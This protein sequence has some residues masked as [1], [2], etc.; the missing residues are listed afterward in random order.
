MAD[1]SPREILERALHLWWAIA[2]CMLL[3]G[4]AA[5]VFS[6]SHSPIYEATALYQVTLDQQQLATRLGLDPSQLP[7]DFTTQNNY[8]APAESIFYLPQVVDKL[9]ADANA[10]GIALT[11]KDFFSTNMFYMDRKGS[12]WIASVRRTNPNEAARLVN[13]WVTEADALLRVVQPH[14][15]RALAL[16][17]QRS[18]IQKCFAGNDFTQA[19]QCAGTAIGSSAELDTT[20]NDLEKQIIAEH[21]AGMGIDPALQYSFSRPA[22]PPL[23]PVLY[24]KSLL[25]LAGA[26]I[27][28]LIGILLVYFFPSRKS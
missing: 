22:S 14:E 8:L 23:E 10:Q 4:I 21:Q 13:L 15:A 20:L 25:I 9:V 26:V 1:I 28:L 17:A 7:L 5:W 6:L 16:Q 12:L 24:N 11:S 2:G 19:N 18:L 3:G 27:G